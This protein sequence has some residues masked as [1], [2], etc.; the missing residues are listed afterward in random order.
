MEKAQPSWSL[1]TENAL[2]FAVPGSAP[3]ADV[4]ILPKPPDVRGQKSS[5]RPITQVC[6]LSRMRRNIGRRLNDSCRGTGLFCVLSLDCLSYDGL[7]YFPQ[8]S[9]LDTRMPIT[10]KIQTKQ[11]NCFFARKPLRL[12]FREHGFFRLAISTCRCR[13]IA[14]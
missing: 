11:P 10:T 2:Q 14:A 4:P 9:R 12:G 3:I 7:A 8:L 13:G 5:A 1:Q 6:A